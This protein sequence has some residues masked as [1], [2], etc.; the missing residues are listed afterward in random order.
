MY[1]EKLCRY[2]AAIVFMAK[3]INEKTFNGTSLRGALESHKNDEMV[4][5]ILGKG[6][7]SKFATSSKTNIN[8][9][10]LF[11]D[12][13]NIIPDD[14]FNVLKRSKVMERNGIFYI[15]F[16]SEKDVKLFNMCMKMKYI[17]TML[18]DGKA[19][20]LNQ[21]IDSM[22]SAGYLN[23]VSESRLK[24][25]SK[26]VFVDGSTS[27]ATRQYV[28]SPTKN[29]DDLETLFA[30][31][32]YIDFHDIAKNGCVF[33]QETIVKNILIKLCQNAII[34]KSIEVDETYLAECQNIIEKKIEKLIKKGAINGRSD[35]KEFQ[36][37]V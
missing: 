23:Q 9:V 18:Y 30:D 3:N 32:F 28:Y 14:I 26:S 31:R 17:N 7:A 20:I 1:E 13:E 12:G 25:N 19:S 16:D 36:I 11:R 29:M 37:S 27:I 15:T 24:V 5:Y 10:T 2:Q 21:A 6:T 34:R 8:Y 33:G 22:I 35:T 4:K